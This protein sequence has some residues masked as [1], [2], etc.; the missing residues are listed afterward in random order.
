MAAGTG[1]LIDFPNQAVN[2]EIATKFACI[3]KA[4][5]LLFGIDYLRGTTG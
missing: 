4:G 1:P 5:S 3:I 2:Q